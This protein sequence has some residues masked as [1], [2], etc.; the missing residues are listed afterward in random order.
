MRKAEERLDEDAGPDH[1]R[2]QVEDADGQRADAGGKLDAAR[3]KLGVQCVCKRELSKTLHGLGD[4]KQRDNPARQVP[5]RVQEAIVTVK[6]DH[7]TNAKERRG[8][9]IVAGEGDPVHEP[10]DLAVSREISLRRFGFVAEKEADPKR[11]SDK[12]EED[13]NRDERGLVDHFSP[14]WSAGSS[15]HRKP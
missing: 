12:Q 15:L 5:D 3:L 11:D 14:S 7:P 13:R 8:G 1:L 6:G 4:D 2:Y 10:R 9:E